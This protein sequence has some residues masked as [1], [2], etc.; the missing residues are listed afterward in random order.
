MEQV[1]EHLAKVKDLPAATLS[2]EERR[3]RLPEGPLMSG[4]TLRNV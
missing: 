2:Q 4:N 1:N 3:E